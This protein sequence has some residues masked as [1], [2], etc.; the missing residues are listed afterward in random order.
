MMIAKLKH[1]GN[2]IKV[3]LN[4]PIDISIPL[5]NGKKNPTAWYVEDVK[6]DA[7]KMGDWIGEVKLGASVNFFN[8]FFNP[9]GHGTHTECVGHIT[10]EKQ[11]VN[12]VIKKFFFFAELISVKPTYIKKDRVIT[13]KSLSELLTNKD[14][15]AVI[16]RTIPNNKDKL[17][18]K[19]SNTNPPYL[20]ESSAKFLNDKKIK[21][22]LIDLP[23]I[24]KEKD[25]GKLLAHHAFWGFPNK[26]R[27]DSSIT[28]FI[29]VPNNIKDGSY[30]LNLSFAPFEN[31]ASPSRPTLYK[32]F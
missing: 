5:R 24:D 32:I 30:L 12:Q 21:H 13:K 7:V 29:Y 16:I 26:T 18:K 1:N 11:S 20:E 19:Y 14:P 2:N 8:I 6:I 10:K 9:H 31:D 22:L 25:D 17:T 27:L 4:K 3:D 28:E 15:E 23:S